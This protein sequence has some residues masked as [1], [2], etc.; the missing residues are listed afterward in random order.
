MMQMLAVRGQFE[1]VIRL[2]TPVEHAYSYFTDFSYVLPRLPEID[3]IIRYRDGRYRMIFSAD[4]G[5]GHEMSIVFDIRHELEPNRSIKM[6][7]VPLTLERLHSDKLISSNNPLFP[8]IFEGETLFVEQ[9]SHTEVIYR[10]NLFI[11]IE[12]PRFL[13][14]MPKNVLQGIGDTLMRL[15]LHQVADG[16]ANRVTA[17]FGNWLEPYQAKKQLEAS[18]SQLAT[19]TQV[20][21]K[22]ETTVEE[23]APLIHSVVAPDEDLTTRLN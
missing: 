16:F 5:R 1:R 22:T 10:V 3:R 15:K 2:N 17:D 9:A 8:G 6:R 23:V 11:E 14:F 20:E 7:S 19:Q 12:V 4:D 13:Q 21:V 18:N